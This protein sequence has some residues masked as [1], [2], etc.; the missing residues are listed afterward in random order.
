MSYGALSITSGI[1][2]APVDGLYT[3][4]V[5]FMMDNNDGSSTVYIQRDGQPETTYGRFQSSAYAYEHD[6]DDAGKSVLM[7]LR[8][9]QTLSL[10]YQ[11]G[12]DLLHHITFCVFRNYT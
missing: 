9:G 8:R 3:V 5:S 7:D 2:T 12:G 6:D 10:F 1:F 4:T 11:S